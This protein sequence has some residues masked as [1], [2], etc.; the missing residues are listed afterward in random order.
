MDTGAIGG[1][2]GATRRKSSMTAT[3]RDEI[4]IAEITGRRGTRSGKL[5]TNVATYAAIAAICTGIAGKRPIFSQQFRNAFP[6]FGPRES[7]HRFG[8]LLTLIALRRW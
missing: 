8:G 7:G 1:T 2:S 5:R 4:F 6:Q 3:K